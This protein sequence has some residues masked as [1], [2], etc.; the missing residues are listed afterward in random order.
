MQEEWKW[1]LGY[2]GRYEVSNMGRVRSFTRKNPII[3]RVAKGTFGHSSVELWNGRETNERR[4][5]HRMVLEAFTGICPH[6]MECCHNNGIPSDNRIAN[7]R[8]D[9][10][11]SNMKDRTRHGTSCA[12]ERNPASIL[13]ESQ[14]KEI[15]LL[16]ATHT[17]VALGKMFGVRKSTISKIVTGKNWRQI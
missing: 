17:N 6:G 11:D 15:K 10:H 8:W 4:L 3:M 5:V 7:L 2:E 9:T 16:H 1:I 13:T 12:G 14:V